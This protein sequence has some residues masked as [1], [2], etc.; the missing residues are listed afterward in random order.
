L[1]GRDQ[2]LAICLSGFL[3]LSDDGLITHKVKMLKGLEISL[4]F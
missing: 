2:E 4:L 1:K 3:T